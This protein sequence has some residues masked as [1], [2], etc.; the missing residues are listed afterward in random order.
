MA[1]RL[2]QGPVTFELWARIAGQGDDPHRVTSEWRGEEELL[3]GR[4]EVTD[5]L[6]DPEVDGSPTVFDPA[7][8]VDGI[9]LS[10][11][12]ILRFRPSAYSE[13]ISRRS[14]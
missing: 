11:D 10:D 7:R 14:S 2:E 4:I 12:P 3:V 5:Q 9:V 6:P 1:A 13:S 8:Q